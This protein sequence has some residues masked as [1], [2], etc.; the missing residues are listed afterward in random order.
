MRKAINGT[1]VN[2]LI[3][4]SQIIN[5]K[6]YK[7]KLIVNSILLKFRESG[8]GVVLIWELGNYGLLLEKNAA[9]SY[10][11]RQRGINTYF[12]L[13]DGSPVACIRRSESEKCF[14]DDP[15]KQCE[16]CIKSIKKVAEDN[17]LNYVFLGDIL[18]ADDK[19]QARQFVND[20]DLA[21]VKGLEYQ[22][23]PIGLLALNSTCRYHATLVNSC[24]IDRGDVLRN[25]LYAGL[26]NTKASIAAIEKYNPT[27]C[28]TS[29]GVYVDYA[30]FSISASR[31]GISSVSWT[32]GFKDMHR[33]Y[34]VHDFPQILPWRAIS[35]SDWLDYLNTD[36]PDNQEEMLHKFFEERYRLG[37]SS[38]IA[39]DSFE[40]INISELFEKKQKIGCLFTHIAW[41]A[42]PAFMD[43]QF[44]SIE[45]WIRLSVK[46][47]I[48]NEAVNWCIRIHPGEKIHNSGDLVE[49]IMGDFRSLP[50]HVKFLD[51]YVPLNSWSLYGQIDFGVTLF[52]TV[53]VEL[54]ALG[55]N[56]ICCGRSHF[57][58]KGFT[59]DSKDVSSY[60][61]LLG[62]AETI[63]TMNAEQV[64]TARRYAYLYFYKQQ[65][66]LHG[67][68]IYKNHS[69]RVKNPLTGY[70]KNAEMT[71]VDK[72]ID[73]II[74]GR[75]SI[76]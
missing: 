20:V 12:V 44:E 46:K 49:K 7:Y 9:I 30:P 59:Y 10:R 18:T 42:S 37:L 61:N 24:D 64:A 23:V 76:N 2:L 29:H 15:V 34:T 73:G 28:F 57:S 69:I 27:A 41:D 47:M 3:R 71:H 25:Y 19:N 4:F 6:I 45:D 43:I 58:G 21:G 53:G 5:Q 35:D 56:I 68:Y 75:F 72:T 70:L 67:A 26:V 32:G 50:P 38:D 74:N 55:K 39:F 17:N 16:Q 48:D 60:L 62:S 1:V 31:R 14:L 63:E 66:P 40:G 8:K 54:P 51:P 33:Y 11:L 22:D 65:I 52:G 36:V 13:C